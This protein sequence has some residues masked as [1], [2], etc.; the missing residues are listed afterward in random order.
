MTITEI[1]IEPSCCAA[2]YHELDLC[3]VQRHNSHKEKGPFEDPLM[4]L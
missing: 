4:Y 3:N 1:N 2:H